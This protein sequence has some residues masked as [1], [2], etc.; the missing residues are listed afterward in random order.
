MKKFH[1]SDRL[2]AYAAVKG[3]VE[4]SALKRHVDKC[5]TCQK[6]CDFA[7]EVRRWLTEKTLLASQVQAPSATQARGR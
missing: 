3:L 6:K 2:L 1:P 4:G 5:K 7:E